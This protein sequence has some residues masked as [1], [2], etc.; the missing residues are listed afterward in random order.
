MNKRDEKIETESG[1][2]SF[3]ANDERSEDESLE[4]AKLNMH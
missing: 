2:D 3:E 1:P 4:A